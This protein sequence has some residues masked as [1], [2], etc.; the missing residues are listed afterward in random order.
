MNLESHLPALQVVIPLLA[1]P[2][3]VLLR[4]R[5]LAFLVVLVASWASLLVSVLL[6]LQVGDGTVISYALGSWPP[7]W[8]IEY[9]WTV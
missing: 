1:A 6:W 5:D 4:Q 2:L 8:G 7:P 9:R 3:T